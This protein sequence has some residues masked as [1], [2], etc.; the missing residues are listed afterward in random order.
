MYIVEYA[1]RFILIDSVIPQDVA[2]LESGVHSSRPSVDRASFF[3]R[4]VE[5]F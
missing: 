3:V 4:S 1:G 2:R 5:L